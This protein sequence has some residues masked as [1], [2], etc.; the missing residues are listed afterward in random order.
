[1]LSPFFIFAVFVCVTV[2]L[3]GV[4]NYVFLHL[5]KIVT[6]ITITQ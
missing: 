6:T 1:V 4:I 5:L 2:P 3:T